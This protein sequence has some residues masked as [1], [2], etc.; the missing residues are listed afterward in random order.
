M[1]TAVSLSPEQKKAK[2]LYNSTFIVVFIVASVVSGLAGGLIGFLIHWLG[3]KFGLGDFYG[4]NL[5]GSF[6]SMGLIVGHL[7]AMKRVRQAGLSQESK[8]IEEVLKTNTDFSGAP[9]KWWY[10]KTKLGAIGNTSIY[11]LISAAGWWLWHFSLA[12]SFQQALGLI[13]FVICFSVGVSGLLF[14]NSPRIRIDEEGIVGFQNYWWP[15]RVLW[16][17]VASCQ[18]IRSKTYLGTDTIPTYLLKNKVG[19]GVLNLNPF[20][21]MGLTLSESHELE[22]EIKCRLTGTNPDADRLANP[23]I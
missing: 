23:P 16:K 5:G 21:Q 11:F 22:T 15:R 13:G 12:S 19:K 9:V 18:I 17:N 3:L 6:A 4:G 14:I 7:W 8:T 2:E 10:P 20:A 1:K